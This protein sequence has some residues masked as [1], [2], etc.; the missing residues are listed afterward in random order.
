MIN[1]GACAY[2]P[3]SLTLQINIRSH[4]TYPAVAPPDENDDIDPLL[5][6]HCLATRAGYSV[7]YG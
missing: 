3:P 1:D 6:I 4:L 5:E 7:T 2:Q